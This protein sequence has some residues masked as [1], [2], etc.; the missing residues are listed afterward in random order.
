MFA[1]LYHVDFRVASRP[2]GALF[3]WL[4]RSIAV[5]GGREGAACSLLTSEDES[6][7]RR[8]ASADESFLSPP[9]AHTA[10]HGFEVP[11]T[12]QIPHDYKVPLTES[13][14]TYE[15]TRSYR[16]RYYSCRSETFTYKQRQRAGTFGRALAWYFFTY[17]CQVLEKLWQ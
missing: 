9:W 17:P 1:C 2:L 12:L 14:N 4:K 16:R 15:A 10:V 6:H 7:I 13:H 5:G 11:S 3:V 8:D